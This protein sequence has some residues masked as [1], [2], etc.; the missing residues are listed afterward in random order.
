MT[1]NT[2]TPP[3][4]AQAPLAVT[5]AALR[6]GKL[7]LL[8]YIKRVCDRVDA[9]DG[10]IQS[11][12]PE[13]ERRARLK[14]EAEALAARYPTPEGRPPLY[15]MLIGVKDIYRV[16]GF[17][18]KAG[19][20]L[21]PE[22]FAGKEAAC[23]RKLRDAG[24]LV[25][26][27][28]VSTEFAYFEPGPTRNPH[29]PAHTPGGSSS[30]SAA[31]AAAG[32]SSLTIGSQTI[33]SVI[34]PASFCGVVGF[35]SSYGRI[36]PAGVIHVAQS[37][38]H[39]GLFTQDVQGM[40]L[41]ASILCKRWRAVKVK[42]MPTLGVPDGPYLAQ[43]APAALQAF[44]A[45]INRLEGA[46]YTVDRVSLFDDIAEIKAA[47][48]ALMAGEAA[49]VH[50]DWFAQHEALYRPRTKE[51]IRTGQGISA[52]TMEKSRANQTLLRQLLESVMEV[53]GIDLWIAPAASGPAPAGIASTG[54][55]AMSFPWT[56]AGLPNIALPAGKIG[57]L[58]FGLQLA[59]AFNQDENVLE[60]AGPIAELLVKPPKPSTRVHEEWGEE[61]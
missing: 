44:E 42:S 34:R 45:H 14:R 57:G 38:D 24:A 40:K 43:A 3:L 53:A 31:A 36:D 33:A 23:V 47:H 54:D 2:T 59:G 16:D 35:K 18:T 20:A 6:S 1:Q 13:A 15:G 37:L 12:L 9:V 39:V 19:S 8:N 49:Q 51:L 22:L 50:R 17:P 10:Q 52:E 7:N 28:T 5:A 60:W 48:L 25:L 56:N 32:L 55:P 41:A 27:K 11:F 30:G 58:P 21:P 46:G 26:G 4:I 29:N 61:I